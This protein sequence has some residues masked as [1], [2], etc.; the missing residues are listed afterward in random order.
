MIIECD[1][2]VF[3]GVV[4]TPMELPEQAAQELISAWEE[5]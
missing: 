3:E 4:Y 5:D 2:I 1:P